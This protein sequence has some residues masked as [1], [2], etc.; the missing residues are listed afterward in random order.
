MDDRVNAP[1]RVAERGRVGELA[2][3]DLDPHALLAETALVAHQRADGPTVRGEPAQQRGA[4]G[5]CGARK[6]NH[7]R[8]AYVL[9]ALGSPLSTRD[10]M[11]SSRNGAPPVST[12]SRPA[13]L[14]S[15]RAA[16][17]ARKSWS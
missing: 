1:E 14:A 9:T 15:S 8:G 2:E 4:H 16:S 10:P 5:A 7:G 6:E 11:G 3:R 12:R 13:R 17:A